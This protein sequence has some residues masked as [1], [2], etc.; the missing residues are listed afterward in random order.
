MLCDIPRTCNTAE[1]KIKKKEEEKKTRLL[2]DTWNIFEQWPKLSPAHY[3]ELDVYLICFA[4]F[5]SSSI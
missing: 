1:Y 4:A 2:E 5:F 3:S